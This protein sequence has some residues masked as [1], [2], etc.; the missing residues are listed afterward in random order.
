MP[1][2]ELPSLVSG[3]V[4]P[5]TAERGLRWLAPGLLSPWISCPAWASAAGRERERGPTLWHL[6][7]EKQCLPTLFG[8][9]NDPTTPFWSVQ[10]P[11]F[12]PAMTVAVGTR[13]V[14]TRRVADAALHARRRRLHTIV[15]LTGRPRL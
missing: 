8:L 9:V 15:R 6:P 10:G 14:R 4:L 1:G 7:A 3:V 13:R 12:T 5:R 11:A 2:D